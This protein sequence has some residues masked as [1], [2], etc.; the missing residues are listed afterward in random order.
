MPGTVVSIAVEKGA[1]VAEGD[2]LVVLSAMKMETVVA[3]PVSGVVSRIAADVADVL[4]AGDL[5]VEIVVG[6]TD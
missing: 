6:N 2:A 4:A 3:S 1:E 5:L